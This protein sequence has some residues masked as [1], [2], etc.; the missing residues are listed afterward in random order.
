MDKKEFTERFLREHEFTPPGTKIYE[1]ELIETPDQTYEVSKHLLTETLTIVRFITVNSVRKD[2]LNIIKGLQVFV[3]FFI[4]GA[5]YIEN[6][7]FW[8]YYILFKKDQVTFIFYL[9]S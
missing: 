1:Y 8:D 9:Q 2:L 3:K 6:T 7:D 4:D 5:S